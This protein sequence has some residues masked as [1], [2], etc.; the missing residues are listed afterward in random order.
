LRFS[1]EPR[2]PTEC[3]FSHLSFLIPHLILASRSP[4]RREIL[5]AAGCDFEVIPPDD[6]AEDRRLPGEGPV[7][8]VKR[9]ARQKAENVAAKI[10]EGIVIGCDTVV[11]C[12][13]EILEKPA[14]RTDAGRML[15]LL[16]GTKHHVITGICL[17]HRPQDT[18]DLRHETTTLFMNE[19]SE[20]EIE[21]YLDSGL[22]AGK[23][24]GFG[25]QDRNDWLRIIDGSESNVVGLPLELL[26]EMMR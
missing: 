24:G 11:V 1:T 2:I 12:R 19:I 13:D 5:Q 22:W 4:R 20:T 21:A 7:D 9:L 16:R 18:V 26:A 23:A 15:R 8:Y 17:W 3:V 14:D 10:A 6:A 25:Y